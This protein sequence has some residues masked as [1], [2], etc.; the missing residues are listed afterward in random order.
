MTD[1]EAESSTA[2]EA[3]P[4]TDPQFEPVVKLTEADKVQAVTG[5]E[6][7]ETLFKMR[8]K[9]FRFDKTSSEWKERGT[10]DLKLLK[11]KQTKRIRV[12]MRRDKTLKICANHYVTSDMKLAPNVGSDRSWVYNVHADISDGEP[13]AE[14]LAVRFAN[15]DNASIFKKEFE[16]AQASNASLFSSS[17]TVSALPESQPEPS[18]SKGEVEPPSPTSAAVSKAEEAAKDTEPVEEAPPGYSEDK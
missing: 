10:G 11:H 5:E 16:D 17:S 15:S 1:K 18:S 6:E 8:A 2:A 3:Q 13:M 4:E 14:T 12:L 9:L 7:E